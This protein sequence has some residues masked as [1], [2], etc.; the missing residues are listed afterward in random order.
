M[1]SGFPRGSAPRMP[2][3]GIGRV[4]TKFVVV[5]SLRSRP[6]LGVCHKNAGC[7]RRG[8]RPTC[9][10]GRCG[11]H[12]S[13]KRK[14]RLPSPE[15]L[16]R[17]AAP[18]DQI[19]TGTMCK[20]AGGSVQMRMWFKQLELI[21]SLFRRRTSGP[22]RGSWTRLWCGAGSARHMRKSGVRVLEDVNRM[23]SGYC[24]VD[25]T[26]RPITS[27]ADFESRRMRQLK[28][29]VEALAYCAPDSGFPLH[30]WD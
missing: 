1:R 26:T 2:R 28:T 23:L 24:R 17:S 18:T 13:C 29:R 7:N 30:R 21:N 4:D 27:I 10:R 15:Q 12:Y 3:R 14:I 8:P 5:A 19:S 22:A 9:V 16:G 6:R 20:Y 25:V 11:L